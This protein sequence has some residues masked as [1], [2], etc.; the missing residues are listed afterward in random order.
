M[1][2]PGT[3]L[4]ALGAQRMPSSAGKQEAEDKDLVIHIWRTAQE[5]CE[6]M[7]FF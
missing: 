1:H 5:T 7:L 6:K 3:A 2:Y 4:A